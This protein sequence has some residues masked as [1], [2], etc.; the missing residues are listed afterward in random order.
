MFVLYSGALLGPGIG[1]FLDSP[2]EAA[3][4]IQVFLLE[5]GDTTIRIRNKELRRI[6]KRTEERHKERLRAN[7]AQK[8]KAK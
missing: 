6:R 2:S 3:I 5:R 8:K 7:K 1:T 4:M